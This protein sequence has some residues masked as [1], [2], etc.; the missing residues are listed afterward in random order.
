MSKKE[1]GSWSAGRI[2]AVVIAAGLLIGVFALP[3][4]K[5]RSPP[6]P[7]KK[8][9]SPKAGSGTTAGGIKPAGPP[10]NGKPSWA[11]KDDPS[12]GIDTIPPR[13]YRIVAD[14]EHLLDEREARRVL[15]VMDSLGIRMM[16]LMG[17]S[18]YTFTLNNRYGFE[19]FKENNETIIEIAKKW[20]DRFVAFPTIFPPEDGNLD[21][22]KDYVRRGAGGLK[23][24]LGH[25]AATGKE[26]FHMMDLDDP[27]MKPIY[28]WAQETQLPIQ[29]HV[30]FTKYVK[31]FRRVMEEFPYLRVC[32]PHF[33]L[34]KNNPKRLKR[35]GALLDRYPNMYSDIS[36]GWYEFQ[37]QG[38][39]KFDKWPTRYRTF[40]E[41][42]AHRF[43]YSADMVVEPTKDHAYIVNTLRSYM[44][45]LE[46]KRYRFFL[47]PDRLY[48]G[49]ALPESA[50]R[51][52]YWE[53]PSAYLL[54]DAAGRP[55]D[56]SRGYPWPGWEGRPMPGLPPTVPEVQPLS[57]AIGPSAVP[58][59]GP[60]AGPPGQTGASGPPAAR[61]PIN[62]R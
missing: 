5:F 20:P 56:R 55:P 15:E 60:P 18:K 61:K 43:M 62:V 24:Y 59:A 47:K 31:E 52:I 37:I 40:M 51:K 48:R 34:F 44:Q 21:L 35:L 9:A 1:G 19:R 12:I 3:R 23:L 7:A 4:G 38:F 41:R 16:A 14:H 30:N 6:S 26:P 8:G 53:T 46:M 22:L 50:L 11:Q 29:L 13:R 54:L 32:V 36:F 10:I 27:R 33:G 28:A 17:T 2:A 45:M 42:Y 57:R 39:Q 58:P 25:G 49:L